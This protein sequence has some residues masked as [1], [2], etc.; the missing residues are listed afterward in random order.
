MADRPT[1]HRWSGH[2]ASDTDIL[3]FLLRRR[4]WIFG[5]VGR[6]YLDTGKSYAGL[7]LYERA[8]TAEEIEQ[9]ARIPLI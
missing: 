6:A 8:L 2:P 4:P 3:N 9:I 7:A 5:E 1:L